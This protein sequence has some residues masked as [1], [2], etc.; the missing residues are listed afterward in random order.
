MLVSVDPIPR[1]DLEAIYSRYP[2]KVGKT[3][4]MKRLRASV[5][6]QADYEELGRALTAYL[7]HVAGKDKQYIRQFDTWCTTWRDWLEPDC[8]DTGARPK[9]SGSAA[10]LEH[11]R[12]QAEAEQAR[13]K[14]PTT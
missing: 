11:L 3:N 8:G 9:P 12:R 2:R 6:S 14:E 7:A 1:F 4:G 13:T 10:A 5:K